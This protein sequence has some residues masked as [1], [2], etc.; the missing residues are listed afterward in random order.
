MLAHKLAAVYSVVHHPWLVA[1][2][3]LEHLQ[4]HG[5]I[6]GRFRDEDY[7]IEGRLVATDGAQATFLVGDPRVVEGLADHVGKFQS[8]GL[9]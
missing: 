7:G 1:V 6:V 3:L 2:G 8:K 5:D 4:T 9:R